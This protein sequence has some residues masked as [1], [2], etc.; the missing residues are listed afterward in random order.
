[1]EN[2][3][4]AMKIAFAMLVFVTALSLA[5]YSFTMVRQTSAQ[6]TQEADVKEYYDRL[7][8]DENES[9]ALAASSRVVGVETVIP[10]LYRYYKENYTVVFYRG[11]GYDE[12]T[13]KFA[14]I[15]PMILYYTE[16]DSNYLKNSSLLSGS[17]GV[18]GFDIQD[19]Q[20]RREPWSAS[21]ATDFNFIRAF[22]NGTTTDKYYTSRTTSNSGRN[23]FSND[24][25][26]LG[27]YYTIDFGSSNNE[28]RGLIGK[29]Y[30]FIER[31]GEYNYNN[32]LSSSGDEDNLDYD[33]DSSITGSVDIL[34][35]GEIVN[36]RNQT[37]KRVI[38]YI[39]IV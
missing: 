22:I 35:N 18:Y 28:L 3:V 11:T 33:I 1:M 27:P 7:T 21:E 13:G 15:E 29:D 12:S 34:D 23:S 20:V 2:A 30:R 26:G 16:T 4:D 37:T 31:N 10:S 5:M 9:S 17:R 8:L 24:N 38:Q 25:D 39:L 14:S 6:I 36:K 32:V 19:E